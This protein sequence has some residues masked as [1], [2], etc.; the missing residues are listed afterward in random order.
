MRAEFDG[1]DYSFY[2]NKG[3]LFELPEQSL[4]AQIQQPFTNTKLNKRAVLKSGENDGPDGIKL[5]TLPEEAQ[6]WDEFKEI[7]VTINKKARDYIQQTGSYGTR[8]NGSDKIEIILAS[9]SF[10]FG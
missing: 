6:T 4:E 1:Q 8:Y 7:N 2:I 5:R 9:D 3:E 10:K